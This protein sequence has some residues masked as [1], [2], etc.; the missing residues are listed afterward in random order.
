MLRGYENAR[1]APPAAK[2]RLF[3]G[4]SKAFDRLPRRDR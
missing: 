4:D 2:K 3:R 1:G